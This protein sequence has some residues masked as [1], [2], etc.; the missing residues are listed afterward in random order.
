MTTTQKNIA[1]TLLLIALLFVGCG[2]APKGAG[3]KFVYSPPEVGISKI[4]HYRVEKLAGNAAYYHLFMNGDYVTFIG[5]GGYYI[6]NLPSGKYTYATK[7]QSTGIGVMV[8]TYVGKEAEN[9]KE[10]T[11]QA[12]TLI[13]EQNKNYYLRWTWTFSGAAEVEQIEE[14]V[15]LKELEGLQ[16]FETKPKG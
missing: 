9:Q 6:Q 10:K 3:P 16:K 13:V 7:R 12:L 1:F 8:I 14:D 11:E 5:N 4:Y 2:H 15:A